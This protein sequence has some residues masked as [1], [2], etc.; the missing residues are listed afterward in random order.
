MKKRKKAKVKKNNIRVIII[1]II[2]LLIVSLLCAGYYSYKEYHKTNIPSVDKLIHEKKKNNYEE[3]VS[4]KEK[5]EEEKAPYVNQLPS[6]R[7]QYGNNN[8]MGRL[9][10]PNL[11]INSLV[12]RT[13][14]NSYYLTYNI[15]NQND[16]LG[17]PFFDYRNI[18]LM[19]DKQVNIYGH[20]TQNEK[21][22]DALPFINL[23]AYIDVNIFNNYKD[24]YL[25][26]DEEQRKYEV[27]A[28]KIITGDDNT[29]MRIRFQN[30]EDFIEHTNRLIS[31]SLYQRENLKI[32]K[33]D[34]ILVLQ[35]C[36]YNPPNTYLL[37]IC[38]KQT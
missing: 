33:E 15:Y 24:V 37:V 9:E 29:H 35:V 13:D 36:H 7:Q 23:E 16:G 38:K 27:V 25:S 32:S 17:V 1:S 20:N 30:D 34:Q 5:V 18:D 12:T 6:Y 26:I 22:F 19:N 2:L 11:N 31:G 3:P 8:I 4:E 14:N 28:I 10:I 21:Y